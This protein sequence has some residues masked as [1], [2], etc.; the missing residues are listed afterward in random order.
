MTGGPFAV[1]AQ[2]SDRLAAMPVRIRY[3][4]VKSPD[5]WKG[6]WPVAV[7]AGEHSK[8]ERPEDAAR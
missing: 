6:D 8:T 5:A 3:L 2:L 1:E 7:P 4:N